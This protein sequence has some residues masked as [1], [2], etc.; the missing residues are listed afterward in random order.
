M[1]GVASG[2]INGRDCRQSKM[3]RFSSRSL[4]R[5]GFTT[6]TKLQIHRFCYLLDS[7]TKWSTEKEKQDSVQF[8]ISVFYILNYLSK[9]EET[10]YHICGQ[11][12]FFLLSVTFFILKLYSLEIAVYITAD[13]FT[14]LMQFQ[15]RFFFFLS[16]KQIS[17]VSKSFF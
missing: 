11:F 7:S 14:D 12:L 4:F 17:Y 13:Y 10:R 8:L 2:V 1:V 3:Q 9:K 15:V 16:L 6:S 5:F